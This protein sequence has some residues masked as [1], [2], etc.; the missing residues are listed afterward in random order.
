[1]RK[2][3]LGVAMA[4]ILGASI[5]AFAQSASSESVEPTPL[6]QAPEVGSVVISS[7]GNAYAG[8]DNYGYDEAA[9]EDALA[10]LTLK[11]VD[12]KLSIDASGEDVRNVVRQ[13]AD[14]FSLNIV[15][16]ETLTGYTTLKLTNVTWKQL[17]DVMLPPAG[18]SYVDDN[19]IILIKSHDELSAEPTE[20]RVFLIN[21]AQAADLS[22]S[23]SPL[24]DPANGGRMQVDR[25]SN[26]LVITE[27][28]SRFN[29]IKDIIERL[30]RPT[31]QVIIE[32][33]FIEVTQNETENLG[34]D[35]QSLN[36]YELSAGPF[37]REWTRG[38]TSASD[39]SSYTDTAVF[40]AGA[41]SAVL[42]AL[43]S[44]TPAKLISNPTVVA[45]NNTDA[46]IN[47]GEEYPIPEYSYN[48]DQGVFEVSG[49]SYKPIGINLHVTPQVN[50]E[51]FIT[52]TIAPEVSSR[53][54]EVTFAGASGA[55][56][57]II[58]TRKTSSTISIKDGYT[59]AIGGLIETKNNKTIAK[60]PFLG[61]IPLA[62]KLFTST[63]DTEESRNLIIFIT[64][65]TVAP[66]G[67]VADVVDQRVM[68]KLGISQSDLPGYEPNAEEQALL[69]QISE[70]REATKRAAQ[71]KKLQ[72]SL[73]KEG[74]VVMDEAELEA[75][76]EPKESKKYDRI[77]KMRAR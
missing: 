64:A 61:D 35:W 26:A 1:M 9:I 25:R 31:P 2:L 43:T 22:A 67:K 72:K 65:R 62:G 75:L 30:D 40:S 29:N 73:R 18:F 34:I 36:S 37:E 38:D 15:I 48:Q 46:M 14:S 60:V 4:L 53:S 41:F 50:S 54:G 10:G 17:F 59:L 47:I 56:I 16:P 69:D 21:Y 66:D 44:S 24:V 45:L 32:S 77:I 23:I 49:F 58:S 7:S 55:S 6:D 63:S 42:S 13:V 11:V 68:N 71:I 12:D 28:P 74:G 3:Y 70:R 52:L 8:S 19:G 33:K 76:Q 57:P 27:R 20:T 39:F 5:V 51:G